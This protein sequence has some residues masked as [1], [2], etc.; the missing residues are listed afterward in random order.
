MKNEIIFITTLLFVSTA[1]AE[2]LKV[3][4]PDMECGGCASAITDRVT[5]EAGVKEVKTDIDGR[6][7]TILTE[8]STKLSDESVKSMVKEA[9]F[10]AE[11]I[12]RF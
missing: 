1:S 11:G 12:E 4:V 9:G 10:T 2:T 5:K 6:T 8:D 3:K 7:V